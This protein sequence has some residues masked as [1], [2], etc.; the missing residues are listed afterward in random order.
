MGMKN[1]AR[2]WSKDGNITVSYCHIGSQRSVYAVPPA[3]HTQLDDLLSK[4]FPMEGM[5]PGEAW[6]TRACLLDPAVL[7][8]HKIPCVRIVQHPG[9]VSFASSAAACAVPD[10]CVC[11]PRSFWLCSLE[12]TCVAYAMG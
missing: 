12:H 10:D 5:P 3:Y 7:R 8:R 9:E 6:K 4:M 1:T 11:I 2:G